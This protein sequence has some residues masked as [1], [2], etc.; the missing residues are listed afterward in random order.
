MERNGCE[1]TMSDPTVIL[2]RISTCPL[3]KKAFN[4]W[5]KAEDAL[6]FLKDN[7]EHDQLVVYAVNRSTFIYALLV[8]AAS[9]T[10]P[11]VDDLMGWRCDPFTSWGIEATLT[12]PRSATILVPLDNTGSNTLDHGEQL[13]FARSFEGRPGKKI[14]HEILQKFTH[15]FGLHF[16]EARNAYCRL[17]KHGDIEDAVRIVTTSA[18]GDDFDGITVT[19]DRSVL[20]EYLAL[21]HSAIV[22]TF[23]FTRYRPSYFSG[24][25]GRHDVHFT[26]EPDLFYRSHI[27][28]GHAGYT[29]GCQIV[30]CQTSIESIIERLDP[31]REKELNY[32]SF[33]TF[34]W[35]NNVVNDISCAPGQTVNYFTKSDL[36][37]ELS[38]AFFR[39]EVLLKYKSDSEKY[40]LKDRS[41][42]CRGAWFLQTY[43][44]NEVGQVHT[45][46]VYLRN[47]PFE[48]Q[49]Y[50]KAYNERPKAPLSERAIKTDFEGRW[51][52]D[53]DPLNSLKNAILDLE[54]NKV[55]WWTLRSS[56]LIEKLFY[57][58][59]NSADEWAN[60][61][62]HLDQLVIEGFETTWLR[63]KAEALGR[64]PDPRFGSLRLVEE[65]LIAFGFVEC[66]ARKLVAPLKEIHNL[67]TKLKGHASCDEAASIRRQAV[68]ESGSYKEHF[69]ALCKKCD[70]AVRAVVEAFKRL[71]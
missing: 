15:A 44:I 55:Q 2:D 6:A 51:D 70:D 41:I 24:W 27:E 61:I 28:P 36:P 22:R 10:P 32:A 33:I 19:V 17:D 23:D 59:T 71:G 62:L 37:F 42:S 63:N 20:D 7:S 45:Y 18:R 57:P 47:L 69:R 21:T 34:D 60:E 54:R 49:L 9:V 5:L 25:K 11:D 12:E 48:E 16:L 39:P 30:R 26:K 14:Y 58:V 40:V 46:L 52:V 56:K 4:E 53:Y 31:M 1:I 3:A 8:P 35:K 64:T 67:R 38:P 43:D 66:D 68:S 13:V 65:C 29:R 50:W